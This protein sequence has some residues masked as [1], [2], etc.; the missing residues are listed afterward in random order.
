MAVRPH[1]RGVSVLIVY[2][3]GMRAID[4]GAGKIAQLPGVYCC[5]A[6]ARHEKAR[7]LAGLQLVSRQLTS[8]AGPASRQASDWPASAAAGWRGPDLRASEAQ[9][10]KSG[11]S[12]W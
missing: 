3:A 8:A 10:L 6:A 9:M 5:S 4:P 11:H 12:S 7:H 1:R 2:H